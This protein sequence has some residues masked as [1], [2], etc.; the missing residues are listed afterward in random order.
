VTRNLT[1]EEW[2]RHLGDEPYR[3]T[4]PTVAVRDGDVAGAVLVGT[5]G[6]ARGE[7]VSDQPGM[8]EEG[9]N[10]LEGKG[11]PL[12]EGGLSQAGKTLGV[13]LPALWAVMTVETK[14][15]GFLPDR[16]PLILF[17]RH[18]FPS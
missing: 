7:G 2:R 9:R 5:R 12:S 6:V 10:M 15:C 17:E 14:G 1:P 16:R 18:V 13:E 3:K 4:C 11:K 8:S